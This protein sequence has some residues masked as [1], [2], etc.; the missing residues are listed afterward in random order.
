MH[1]AGEMCHPEN[2]SDPS[3]EDEK[4]K[5][6]S[7]KTNLVVLLPQGLVIRAEGFQGTLNPPVNL[8]HVP[9]RVRPQIPQ[10]PPS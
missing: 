10:D 7:F 4:C 5:A 3:T 1:N 2:Q 9:L 8:I 6:G